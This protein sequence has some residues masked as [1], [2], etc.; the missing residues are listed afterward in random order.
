MESLQFKERAIRVYKTEKKKTQKIH[1]Q[2]NREH[3]ERT[4][5]QFIK[6]FEQEPDFVKRSIVII[7]GIEMSYYAYNRWQMKGIC[8]YC[9]EKAWSK[10][11]IKT[12][13]DVGQLLV[14]FI[15]YENHFLWECLDKQVRKDAMER[16]KKLYGLTDH[17]K[18][19]YK[20]LTR[21]IG[22]AKLKES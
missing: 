1:K 2:W 17:E 14:E 21:E 6:Q 19:L 5:Q 9:R 22:I 18:D 13:K 3:T 8:P 11:C 10:D 4:R 20:K 15:P 7:D 12:M 16:R